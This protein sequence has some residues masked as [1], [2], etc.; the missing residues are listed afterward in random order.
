MHLD[1]HLLNVMT[2]GSSVI[3]VIDWENV[4]LDDA[5]LDVAR[6]LSILCADPSIRALPGSA[7][8]SRAHV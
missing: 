3:S 8:A 2:D 4:R 7:A 6:T 1:Y 5:R